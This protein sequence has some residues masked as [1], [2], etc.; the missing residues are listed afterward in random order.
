MWIRIEF[1]RMRNASEKNLK[2]WIMIRINFISVNN[3]SGMALAKLLDS[4]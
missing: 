1:I 3:V 2:T 4:E